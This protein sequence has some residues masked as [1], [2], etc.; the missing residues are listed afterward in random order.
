M[1]RA[2]GDV[3]EVAWV[4]KLVIKE[5]FLFIFFADGQKV[6][7]YLFSLVNLI[8]LLSNLGYDVRV[9]DVSRT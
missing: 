3:N 4:S 9:E 8:Q 7:T 2:I 5:G 1:P 6:F